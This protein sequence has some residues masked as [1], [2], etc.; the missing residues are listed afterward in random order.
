[1]ARGPQRRLERV[2]EIAGEL[3]VVVT[4]L[5]KLRKGSNGA[6]LTSLITVLEKESRN[7]VA[8]FMRRQRHARRQ[9]RSGSGQFR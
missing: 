3:V 7:A 9:P 5:E 4:A 2:A 1:M 8:A 6:A